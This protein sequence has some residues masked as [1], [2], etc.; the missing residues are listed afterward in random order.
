MLPVQLKLQKIL[1]PLVHYAAKNYF[2]GAKLSIHPRNN[3]LANAD[4][5][6]FVMYEFCKE[7]TK[8]M[9][10]KGCYPSEVLNATKPTL[11]PPK[12]WGLKCFA[13]ASKKYKN[14]YCA[15]TST[16]GPALRA[17]WLDSV[18]DFGLW[19]NFV[20]PDQWSAYHR[21]KEQK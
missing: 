14:G 15:G 16:G 8:K 11:V 1:T 17:A 13:G 19:E 7:C 10:K 18:P 21:S 6:P 4:F 12:P 20:E 2:F 3:R 9:D 5:T